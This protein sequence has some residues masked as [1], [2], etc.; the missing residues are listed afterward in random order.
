MKY[1]DVPT[2]RDLTT[3]LQRAKDSIDKQDG[4]GLS[5]LSHSKTQL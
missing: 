4:H 3:E 5:T 1:F 2:K